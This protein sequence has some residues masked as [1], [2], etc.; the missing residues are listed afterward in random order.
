MTYKLCSRSNG[1]TTLVETELH[2]DEF[3]QEDFLNYSQGSLN[4][5]QNNELMGQAME[6]QNFEWWIEE[7]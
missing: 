7:V 6:Q 2:E 1:P 4:D 5:E 3:S